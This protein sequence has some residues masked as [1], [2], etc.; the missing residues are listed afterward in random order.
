MATG[1]GAFPSNATTFHRHSVFQDCV[2]AH[3]TIQQ[4]QSTRFAV[5]GRIRITHSKTLSCPQGFRMRQA[6]HQPLNIARRCIP[7]FIA[8]AACAFDSLSRGLFTVRSLYLSAIGLATIFSLGRDAPAY[9][10]SCNLK[11]LYSRGAVSM[12]PDRTHDRRVTGHFTLS[13]WLLPAGFQSICVHGLRQT[14]INPAE[15]GVSVAT[16]AA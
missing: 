9:E 6:Q 2:Q 10:S 4:V 1:S 3:T 15:L 7:M 11:K 16:H 13:C 12:Q 5:H 8:K 14:P